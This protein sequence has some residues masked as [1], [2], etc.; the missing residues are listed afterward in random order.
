[1]PVGTKAQ[2]PGITGAG[3]QFEKKADNLALFAGGASPAVTVGVTGLVERLTAAQV[4]TPAVPGGIRQIQKLTVMV[5]MLTQLQ[6]LMREMLSQ[7]SK[8]QNVFNPAAEEAHEAALVNMLAEAMKAAGVDV[9]PEALR[10]LADGIGA[11]G[12]GAMAIAFFMMTAIA[13]AAGDHAIGAGNP[14]GGLW[15]VMIDYQKMLN[16]ERRSDSSQ[17]RQDVRFELKEKEGKFGLEKE[18]IDAMK[19]EADERFDHAMSAAN[20]EMGMGIVSCAAAASTVLGGASGVLG[21]AAAEGSK[22]AGHIGEVTSKGLNAALVVGIA[23]DKN[24]G[25]KQTEGGKRSDEIQTKIFD[26]EIQI[27]RAGVQA[28]DSKESLEAARD[29]KKA[30]MDSLQKFLDIMRAMNPQI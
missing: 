28:S 12:K 26:K 10:S 14:E 22:V 25:D 5:E 29:R 7:D 2:N 4:A 23:E 18:K 30:G 17:S 1:M 13:E 6:P 20:K 3:D 19:A 15:S 11:G 24:W 21:E 16:K 8:L 27:N 9:D